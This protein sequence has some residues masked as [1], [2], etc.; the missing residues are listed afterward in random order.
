MGYPERLLPAVC[1]VFLLCAFAAFSPLRGEDGPPAPSAAIRS[2]TPVEDQSTGPAQKKRVALLIG[3]SDYQNYADLRNPNNDAR[4]LG[5][6]LRRL[7][8]NVAVGV[9]LDA[10]AFRKAIQNFLDNIDK[11][12]VALFFYAGHGVQV[13]GLN[14]MLPTDAKL[15]SES[16]LEFEAIRFNYLLEPLER[17]SGIGIVFLDACRDNPLANT[18]SGSKTRSL[19]SSRGLAPVQTGEGLFIGYATQ[20][21]NVASDGNGPNSPFTT[22]LLHHLE[23]PGYDIEMLMRRVRD[24]VIAATDHAQV[25]WS[26]SSL[27]SEGFSFKPSDVTGSPVANIP[28]DPER[29]LELEL[30]RSIG[31]S[32]DPSLLEGYLRRYPK[33]IFSDI[34]K[35]RLKVLDKKNK[36]T[37]VQPTDIRK[38]ES[39]KKK[40]VKTQATVQPKTQPAERSATTTPSSNIRQSRLTCRDG[41]AAHCRIRCQQGVKQACDKLKRIGF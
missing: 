24:D 14:Y 33:G 8:F 38:P 26:N 3:N 22:A 16:D 18:L 39:A 23:T 20:P 35:S 31:D 36:S 19:M 28:P 29:Q 25:P 10:V 11:N 7:D 13:N 15:T 17:D 9:D 41:N 37:S 27:S 5:T 34:A 2:A 21:D 4:A 1:A 40:S 12:T 6:V 32:T 30:W